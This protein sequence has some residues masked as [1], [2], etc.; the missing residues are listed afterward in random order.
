M[1]QTNSSQRDEI[2]TLKGL[3]AKAQALNKDLAAQQDQL[4]SMETLD[5]VKVELASVKQA[6]EKDLADR[7]GHHVAEMESL[8]DQIEGLEAECSALHEE[9]NARESN[10]SQVRA[11]LE[12]QTKKNIT[13]EEK[14][15][16][17]EGVDE[18]KKVLEVRLNILMIV[19]I[20]I[21]HY[22]YLFTK[23]F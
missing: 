15:K 22:S 19:T 18:I 6:Y 14:F 11:D 5:A 12:A 3:Y 10:L 2:D 23:E 16:S 1:E 17:V 13:L 8:N 20:Y 21:I 7:D 4:V 9:K